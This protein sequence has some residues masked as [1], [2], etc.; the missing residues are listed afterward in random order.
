MTKAQWEEAY[1]EFDKAYSELWEHERNYKHGSNKKIR[2]KADR[3]MGYVKHTIRH[4]FTKYPDVYV[5][6]T[7]G[8]NSSDYSRTIVMDEF[9]QNR[10]IVDDMRNLLSSMKE[11]IKSLDVV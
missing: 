4:L 7:G 10:Y 2:E 11:K 6:A 1:L 8:E 5:L 3:Q 9:F